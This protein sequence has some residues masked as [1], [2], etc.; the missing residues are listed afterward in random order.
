MM[1]W[2]FYLQDKSEEVKKQ[3]KEENGEEEEIDDEEEVEGEEEDEED[4]LPEGDDDLD[5]G[6]GRFCHSANFISLSYVC[7]L[8]LILVQVS[9]MDVQSLQ[10]NFVKRW[11]LYSSRHYEKLHAEKQFQ[12]M[13]EQL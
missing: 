9:A 13:H 2:N 10:S 12:L 4:E 8:L 5:E 3:K 7:S 6:E 11:K 1:M